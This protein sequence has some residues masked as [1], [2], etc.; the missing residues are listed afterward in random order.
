MSSSTCGSQ[1]TA[2]WLSQGCPECPSS[3]YLGS[4]LHPTPSLSLALGEEQ[5][6]PEEAP[7]ASPQQGPWPL[8]LCSGLTWTLFQ[9]NSGYCFS[10]SGMNSL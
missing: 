3:S 6:H 5:D 2:V 4:P 9:R 10:N 1:P 8:Q 7:L